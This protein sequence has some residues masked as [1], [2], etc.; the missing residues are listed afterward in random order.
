M[1]EEEERER[2][3]QER[4]EEME[5]HLFPILFAMGVYTED[6]EEK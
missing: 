5:S 1:K 3:E 2:K 6:E 4:R